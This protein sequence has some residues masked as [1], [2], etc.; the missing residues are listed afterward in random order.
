MERTF[1]TVKTSCHTKMF[2]SQGKTN[3]TTVLYL[4]VAESILNMAAY[5]KWKAFESGPNHVN[6]F[7]IAGSMSTSC[8]VAIAPKDSSDPTI[9][10]CRIFLISSQPC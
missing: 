5:F 9:G 8:T 7:N 10:P 2:L 1:K 4:S 3:R 6:V